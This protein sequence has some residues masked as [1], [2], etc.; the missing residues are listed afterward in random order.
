MSLPIE[1]IIA[2]LV[3]IERPLRNSTLVDLS[4]LSLEELELLE[5]VWISIEP[6]R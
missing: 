2:D 4:N 6:E 3:N 5:Q 1:E